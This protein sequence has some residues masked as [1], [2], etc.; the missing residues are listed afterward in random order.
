MFREDQDIPG[1]SQIV[2]FSAPESSAEVEPMSTRGHLSAKQ[3][4]AA[5]MHP[6]PPPALAV[7]ER[8]TSDTASPEASRN[9]KLELGMTNSI[10]S[11]TR[12]TPAAF[13]GLPPRAP[14]ERSI[15]LKKWE[16]TV[17]S[18]D[19]SVAQFVARLVSINSD[20]P[21]Y[22]AE[23]SVDEVSWTDR[24]L[25]VTGAIFYW[26]VGYR[27]TVSGTRYKASA[28]RFRRL[29]E[30]TQSEQEDAVKAAAKLRAELGW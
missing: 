1:A 19:P 28:L 7:A 4:V 30:I 8:I 26:W 13:V 9:Q 11:G 10:S 22:S 16:G 21:D 25:L 12:S 23:F 18:I 3:W 20:E 29:P 14:I 6:P 15:A 2:A 27:E 24:D 17:L 5:T